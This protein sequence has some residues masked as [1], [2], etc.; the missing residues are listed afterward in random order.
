[1]VRTLKTS[2]LI[3]IGLFSA[4][5]LIT[6]IILSSVLFTPVL[7]M[8]MLPIGALLMGPVY[9]LFIA[10]TQTLGAITIMGL[11]A[12]A[13]AGLLVYGNVLIALVNLG[14]ALLAELSAYLGKYKSF[15]WNTISFCFMSLWPIGQ[16]GGLWVARDWMRIGLC[17]HTLH[18]FENSNVAFFASF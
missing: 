18:F 12:A 3:T 4:I 13:I 2:D 8:F 7:F 1:M 6:Y 14:F 15:W 10:R 5:Y 11:L 16:Q 9:M 17:A